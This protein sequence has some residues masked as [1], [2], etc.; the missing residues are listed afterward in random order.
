[1]VDLVKIG[2]L[3]SADADRRRMLARYYAN[4][5]ESDRLEAHRTAGLLVRSMRGGE[6]MD[7]AFFYSTFMRA[8]G[9]MYFDRQETLNRKNALTGEQAV[10]ISQKRLASFRSA[11]KDRLHKRRAKKS[12]LI[13]IQYLELIKKL[14][15]DGLSWRDCAD[16]LFKYH[17]KKISHQYLKE[18]YEKNVSK[19][20]SDEK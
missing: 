4:M 8:L 11:K 5:S 14:R 17:K 10:A 16:Y 2:R 1:M 7:E 15:A 3:S 12:Q 6:I 18:I 13:S 19:E 20:E 9:Q